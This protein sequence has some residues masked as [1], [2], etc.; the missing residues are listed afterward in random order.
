[1]QAAIELAKEL[2]AQ[3]LKEG[4]LVQKYKYWRSCCWYKSTNTDAS[5]LCP[6]NQARLA[7]SQAA[8]EVAEAQRKA[9]EAAREKEKRKEEVYLNHT[10]AAFNF[11]FI[12][13]AALRSA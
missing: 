1:M 4:G 3:K 12:A 5:S 10:S 13:S 2:K 6:E 7:A 9:A 8:K 11:F